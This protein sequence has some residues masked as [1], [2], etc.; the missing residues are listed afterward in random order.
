MYRITIGE[1]TPLQSCMAIAESTFLFSQFGKASLDEMS[2]V[3]KK[4][5][6]DAGL[7]GHSAGALH[8]KGKRARERKPQVS[9]HAL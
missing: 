7:G 3:F 2:Y 8:F 6:E 1:R 9:F 5:R 4:P